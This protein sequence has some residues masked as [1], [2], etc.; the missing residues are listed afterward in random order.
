MTDLLFYTYYLREVYADTIATAWTFEYDA[1]DYLDF[2]LG[3]YISCEFWEDRD[4]YFFIQKAPCAFS[5][6][7]VDTCR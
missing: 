5:A 2:K 7:Y 6:D 3:G 4:S 1:F